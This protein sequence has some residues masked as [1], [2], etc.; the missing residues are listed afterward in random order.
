MFFYFFGNKQIQVSRGPTLKS[1]L[2][3]VSLNTEKTIQQPN[4]FLI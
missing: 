3:L 1:G 4:L 2:N